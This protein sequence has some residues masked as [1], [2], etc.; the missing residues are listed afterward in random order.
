VNVRQ[1]VGQAVRVRLEDT[2]RHA[3]C[4][5]VMGS[6]AF[7]AAAD[8]KRY[9][10]AAIRG[11]AEPGIRFTSGLTVCDETLRAGQWVNLPGTPSQ[12]D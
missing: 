11:G 9:A 1:I 8:S 5:L 4:L 7:G 3:L 12:P 6:I 2:M 10:S